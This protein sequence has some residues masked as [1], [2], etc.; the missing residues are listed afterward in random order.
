MLISAIQA[1]SA[2]TDVAADQRGIFLSYVWGHVMKSPVRL[3]VAALAVAAMT[4]GIAAPAAAQEDL[5]FE[6][7]PTEGFPGDIVNGQV[8]VADVAQ[9]CITDPVEFV[10]QF[11]DLEDPFSGVS[12]PYRAALEQWFI[13]NWPTPGDTTTSEDPLHFAAFVATFFP[14]GLALDLPMFGGDGELIEGA[15][16]QTFVMTF[17]DIATQEPVGEMGNFDRDT[18]AGQVTV[19]DVAPGL[20][21][22]AAACV[23]LPDEISVDDID[24]ALQV[25]AAF[26]EANF[27]TPYPTGLDTPEFAAAAGQIAPVIIQELVEPHALGFELFDVLSD[28][29]PPVEE[30]PVD[31][32]AA[33]KA[34]AKAVAKVTID[35]TITGVDPDAVSVMADALGVD[36][37]AT[38]AAP[39]AAPAAQAVEAA[40]TFT[41]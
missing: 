2:A 29:E 39:T 16:A 40:P 25:A 28:E 6:I 30:P 9:H 33:A 23:G 27:E 20:W 36:V 18:G 38:A 19:P 31:E 11:V 10:E 8:D 24:A 32:A 17:A 21:A 3:A 26:V 15:L 7:D 37:V 35:I 13:E 5:G 14:L 34:V 4:L 1:R 41:G 12:P 22:V